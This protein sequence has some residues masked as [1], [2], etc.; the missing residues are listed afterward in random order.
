MSEF[1]SDSENIVYRRLI[2]QKNVRMRKSVNADTVR[3]ASL[4]VSLFDVYPPFVVSG[5]QKFAVIF[6]ERS[7]SF[8]YK[9][10]RV[11]VRHC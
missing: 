3:A 4:A 8:S 9:F 1:V 2:V 7:Q 5:L 6:A 11:F 10:E